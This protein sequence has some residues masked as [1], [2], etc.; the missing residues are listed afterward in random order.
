[1]TFYLINVI[2]S[3]IELMTDKGLVNLF[4]VLRSFEVRG[5]GAFKYGVKALCCFVTLYALLIDLKKKS[6]GKFKSE[7]KTDNPTTLFKK[8]IS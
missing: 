8:L 1:M 3:W 5:N 6:G 7:F 2:D 4:T